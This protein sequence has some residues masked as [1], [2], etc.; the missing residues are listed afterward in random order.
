[1]RVIA[2]VNQKGGVG[3]TATVVN[4]G[5]ALARRGHRMAMIDLDPQGHLA[6][7]LGHFRIADDG[8]GRI[9]LGEPVLDQQWLEVRDWCRLL[10]ADEAL[11]TFEPRSGGMARAAVLRD[12]LQASPPD[13]DTLLV[14]C[15][16]S[17]GML[18]V[19][20]LTA[21]D[22]VLIPVVGDYLSLAGLGRLMLTIRR[23][24]RFLRPG[25]R[26]WIFMS[27]YMPR[28]RLA[29][30]VHASVG[31]HFPNSLLVAQVSEA[32]ALAE[33]AG[34]GAS[35]F[36]HQPRSKSAAEVDALAESLINERVVANER[37]HTSHV[38]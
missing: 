12:A 6:A 34:V 1:M 8:T 22:D 19:N 15:P 5:H 35:I 13:V 17:A 29:R 31:R 9:L 18:I 20:A 38:A 27:R 21:A 24:K 25:L 37:E 33:C 10:P 23:L 28:R 30:E 14:D 2:V 16:P 32:A 4:L 11:A 3:K 26:K 7:S 36:E